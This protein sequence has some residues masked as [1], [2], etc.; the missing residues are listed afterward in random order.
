M[1]GAAL[2]TALEVHRDIRSYKKS[3]H[4]LVFSRVKAE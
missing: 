4:L 3:A 1:L 2:M